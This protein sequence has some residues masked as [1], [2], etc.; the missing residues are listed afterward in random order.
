MVAMPD[1]T[2][3]ESARVFVVTMPGKK[4]SSQEVIEFCK[5]NLA[6]YKKPK[7][8]DFVDELPR[9]ASGKVL[10]RQLRDVPLQGGEGG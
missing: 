3:G 4:L 8:V 7:R 1:P 6:S 10:K 9:N 5:Q 2:W